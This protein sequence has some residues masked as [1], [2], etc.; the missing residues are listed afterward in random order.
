MAGQAHQPSVSPLRL[1]D[2]TV[3]AIARRL[4]ANRH[5]RWDAGKKHIETSACA[6][7]NRRQKS[8]RCDP[9]RYG[10]CEEPG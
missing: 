8:Q 1:G 10:S 3:S 5:T 4:G 6:A 7:S 9:R 2:A